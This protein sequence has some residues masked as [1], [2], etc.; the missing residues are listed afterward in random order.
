MTV[1][2]DLEK[3]LREIKRIG[4]SL[5]QSMK[6]AAADMDRLGR[7][8]LKDATEMAKVGGKEAEQALLRLEQELKEGGPNIRREMDDV[9]RRLEEVASRLEQDLKRFLK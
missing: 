9:Q 5:D 4:S 7:E 6:A 3:Y 1:E 2:S 8:A